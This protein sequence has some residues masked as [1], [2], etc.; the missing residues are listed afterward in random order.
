MQLPAQVVP[1]PATLDTAPRGDLYR[2]TGATFAL[3]AALP[4]YLEAKLAAAHEPWA[5]LTSSHADETVLEA[6]ATRLYERV[7]AEQPALLERV[8]DGWRFPFTGVRISSVGA[9]MLEISG[10]KLE[11]LGAR[12]VERANLQHGARARILALALNIQDDLA[13]MHRDVAE[14]LWVMLPSSWNPLEKIGL[15]LAA[16]HAPV[17][18]STVLQNATPN[19]TKAVLERG[20]FERFVWTLQAAP[21]LGAHPA[22][23]VNDDGGTHW[24]VERQTFFPM[25]D[26]ERYWFVIRVHVVPLETVLNPERAVALNTA[27]E[28]I[29]ASLTQHKRLEPLLPRARAMLEPYLK[30]TA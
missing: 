30:A 15:P 20:P 12:I 17:P 29:S 24:R 14:G 4:A 18:N 23:P 1:W 7:H 2:S 28:K 8:G 13:L 27:L 26:L 3:D 6:C 19:L 22:R 10:A 16:I 5:A 11:M 21:N 9:V 25:P